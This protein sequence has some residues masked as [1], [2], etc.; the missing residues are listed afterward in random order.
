MMKLRTFATVDLG[1]GPVG[2][3]DTQDQASVIAYVCAKCDDTHFLMRTSKDGLRLMFTLTPAEANQLADIL[4]N[5]PAMTIDQV[6]AK[7]GMELVDSDDDLEI[8]DFVKKGPPKPTPKRSTGR[9]R[10]KHPPDA[11]T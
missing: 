2:M 11:D 10:R 1:I 4:L 8:P 5:P 6:A 7:I 3:F 9:G